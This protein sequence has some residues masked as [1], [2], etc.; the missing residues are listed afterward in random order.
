[1]PTVYCVIFNFMKLKKILGRLP[2]EVRQRTIGL[3]SGGPPVAA[4]S[5]C[6]LGICKSNEQSEQN[7]KLLNKESDVQHY[8]NLQQTS[9]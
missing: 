7:Q 3:I 8:T 4:T 6:Y 1:M 5:A 2:P 9:A